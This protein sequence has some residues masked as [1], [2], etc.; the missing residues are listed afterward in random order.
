MNPIN[1][2]RKRLVLIRHAKSSWTNPQLRDFDRPL[3]K[4]GKENAPEMG[5][6]LAHRSLMPDR[7]ISSPAK[8]AISTAEIIAQAI[9]F[10]SDQISPIHQAYEAG[11]PE[12]L[13]VLRKL[14]DGDEI[15]V[16]VGHNPALTD[17]INITCGYSLDNLPTCGVF[18]ADFDIASWGQIDGHTGKLAFVDFPKRPPAESTR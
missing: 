12:L 8:R 6:R 16:L 17:L 11:A 14:D 13:S 3:N 2:S 18:C 10:P 5:R 1:H 7:L 9:G 15:V 4:R